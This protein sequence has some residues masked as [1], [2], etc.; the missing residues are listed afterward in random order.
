MFACSGSCTD[1]QEELRIHRTSL[2]SNQDQL[3]VD[4]QM[5]VTSVTSLQQPCFDD[6]DDTP[7]KDGTMLTD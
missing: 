2:P 5:C 3:T 1:E 6:L 4:T 7:E